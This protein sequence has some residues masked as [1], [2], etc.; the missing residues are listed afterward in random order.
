MPSVYDELV[1]CR[2]ATSEMTGD[3]SITVTADEV[4]NI[5]SKGV[6]PL[7]DM[8]SKDSNVNDQWQNLATHIAADVKAGFVPAAAAAD[9]AINASQALYDAITNWDKTAEPNSGVDAVAAAANL[10]AVGFTSS[11]A[12]QLIAGLAIKGIV[13]VTDPAIDAAKSMVTPIVQNAA[14]QLTGSFLSQA[15]SGLA[16]GAM[17]SG[18]GAAIGAGIS[19]ISSVMQ[20]LFAPP[21]LPPY[22]V[23]GCGIWNQPD[24]VVKYTW[25]WGDSREASPIVGGG[26]NN[27]GWRTFPDPKTA[28]GW[29]DVITPQQIQKVMG[30]NAGFFNEAVYVGPTQYKWQ[31][32]APIPTDLGHSDTWYGCFTMPGD[33]GKR[34]IDQAM[35]DNGIGT[36]ANGNPIKT[37]E[38]SVFHQLEAEMAALYIPGIDPRQIV[39]FKHFQS[40][41]FLLWKQNRE[42]ALNGLGAQPDWK[43]LVHAVTVWNNGHAADSLLKVSP[44]TGNLISPQDVPFVSCSYVQWLLREYGT[45][46]GA[47]L[48]L[49]GDFSFDLHTGNMIVS[50]PALPPAGA[51]HLIPIKMAPP[52][53]EKSVR[54][55]MLVDGLLVGGT[56]GMGAAGPVGAVIGAGVGAAVGHFIPHPA[57]APIV[58]PS[59]KPRPVIKAEVPVAFHVTP[60]SLFLHG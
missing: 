16:A 17:A 60:R 33:V 20:S 11:G 49:D 39:Q 41:F 51:P 53:P 24:I 54:S 29:F 56:V 22:Q 6:A 34:P 10:V 46:I 52:E 37:Q 42:F 1:V 5:A 9:R 48:V 47:S 57:A 13:A 12:S 55:T 3:V 59:P 40:L 32:K 50:H 27:P 18:V 21:P 15:V 30:G 28:P 26:P 25:M 19:I 14:K 7:L 38:V 8:A 36:D 23:G 31:Y 45:Q 4:K 58:R 44:T 2:S 35:Y 43:V